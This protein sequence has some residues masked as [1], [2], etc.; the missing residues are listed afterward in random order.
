MVKDIHIIRLNFKCFLIIFICFDEVPNFVL[1]KCSIKQCLEMTR[2]QTKRWWVILNRL[3]E[4]LLLSIS[5]STIVEE[6]SLGRVK[7]NCSC[8]VFNCLFVLAFSI[9]R[10][11]SVI[12]SIWI[13]WINLDCQG[14][15]LDGSIEVVDFVMRES[16]IEKRFEVI[17][18]VGEGKRVEVYG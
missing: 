3:F 2:L 10:Y 13:L 1:A 4:H 9:I 18:E 15:I 8:E 6:I 7:P 11:S 14:I 16:T 12:I 5:K 17:G